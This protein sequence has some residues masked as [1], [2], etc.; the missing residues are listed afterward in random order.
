MQVTLVFYGKLKKDGSVVEQHIPVDN[1]AILGDRVKLMQTIQQTL[2]TL[3]IGGMVH[4]DGN[5]MRLKPGELFEEMWC[6]IPSILLASPGE[7]IAP[8]NS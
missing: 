8:T 5:T 2:V 7:P 6:E 1:P 3:G 4:K